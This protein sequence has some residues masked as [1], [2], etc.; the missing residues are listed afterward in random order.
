[1][2]TS[3]VGEHYHPRAGQLPKDEELLVVRAAALHAHL[4]PAMAG[5]VEGPQAGTGS[6]WKLAGRPGAA[7]KLRG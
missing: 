5:A 7:R 2:D 1:M 4:H 3:F 6:A